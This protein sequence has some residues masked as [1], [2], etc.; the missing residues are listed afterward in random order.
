[1]KN[2]KPAANGGKKIDG[3]TAKRPGMR[4]SGDIKRPNSVVNIQPKPKIQTRLQPNISTKPIVAPR[5]SMGNPSRNMDVA[6]SSQISRF[7]KNTAASITK[8]IKAA[9]NLSSD[10]GHIRHPLAKKADQSRNSGIQQNNAQNKPL[11]PKEIKEAA[12]AEA[13]QKLAAHE[14]QESNARKRSFKLVNIVSIVIG[15]IFLAIITYLVYINM[16]TLSVSIASAQAGINATFPE[17]KPDGYTINGPVSYSDGQVT[18]NFTS[19]NNTSFAVKQSKSSWDSSA[20]KS[21]VAKDSNNHFTTTEERGLTIFV[22]DGDA[23]WVN[24]GILYTI[25]GDAPLTSDQIRRI[26]TSL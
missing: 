25:S 4:M 11:T 17:Y 21:K 14:Q 13:F 5:P 1:M 23:A 24:G 6:R 15:V 22:Y 19:S 12:I 26:A 3:V 7:A 8:P 10:I 9:V 20:V 16:P 2:E 18:I